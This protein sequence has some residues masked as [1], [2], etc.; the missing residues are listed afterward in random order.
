MTA[1]QHLRGFCLVAI[2]LTASGSFGQEAERL[3]LSGRDKDDAVPWKFKCTSG[4]QSGFWTNLPVPSHWEMYGFGSLNY[5]KDPTN[6]W[7]EQGLYDHEFSIPAEWHD[8]RVFLVFEGVMTDTSARLNGQSVGPMHQGSFYRFKYEVT[9]LAKCGAANRLEVTV[10]KHS[11]NASVNKAERNADYWVFG[12]IY[13]P[14][15]LEAVPQQFIDRVAIDAQANGAL[16]VEAF[17]DGIPDGGTI[18]AQVLQLDGKP[19]GAAF[20]G[21]V[22]ASKATLTARVSR[23][24]TWTAETPNLY[25]LQ[26]SFKQGNRIIHMRRHRFGFR[27]FEV[28][29]G[30]GLYLN[31]QRV[32][33]Q[34]ADRH[35][36]WPESGRCLSEAIHRLD[37]NALKD[38]NMNAV[39]MSHYPPDQKFLDL[40]DEMGIYVLDE[41]GGWHQSYD[42]QVGTKL[43]GEMIARDVNHPCILFWDNG[44]EG[45]WNTNLDHLFPELDVQHRRVLHPWAPFSGVNTAHYLAYTQAVKACTGVADVHRGKELPPTNDSTRYIYMP[46]EFLHGLYDGGAGAGMEDYWNLMRSSKYLG[47]SF[48][49][50]LTDDGIRRP[51]TGRI[52]VAGNQAPDGIVG[53]YRQREASYYAIKEIWSPIVVLPG[54]RLPANEVRIA[55]RYSFTDAKQCTFTWE[56]RK[57][58]LPNESA[59]GYTVLA[60]GKATV[61]SIWPGAT[62]AIRLGLPPDWDRA[63]AVTL[64]VNDPSGRELWTWVWP[65]L[66]IERFR[67]VEADSEGPQVTTK[68]S[69][70]SIDIRAGDLLV[71]ISKQ[72]GLLAAVQRGGQKYSINNGPRP[73]AGE[74]R[75][76]SLTA[77]P[78]NPHYNVEGTF[79]GNLSSVGWRLRG[80]G[81]LD[82]DYIYSAT[83]SMDFHGVAFDFPE[84]GVKHKKWLGDGPYRVWKNRLQ[85]VSLGIWENDY[86]NTITGWSDWNYPEFK[87]CFADVRWMQF[88]TAE[89]QITIL[90]G[91]GCPFVQVL[92]PEFPPANLAGKTVPMLPRAGLALLNAIPPMGSKFTVASASGPQGQPNAGTGDYWGSISF[93][94]GP[95]PPSPGNK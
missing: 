93:Y 41:L 19:V 37:I 82:C 48:V 25:E 6:A 76:K 71:Q 77:S 53:P 64:Q 90:P 29:D 8:R 68:G 67:G 10:A 14:I 59:A 9:G 78:A 31:G 62:N 39:R 21:G 44:N 1:R 79:E 15:Y 73:A 18:E 57:F 38:A 72:S 35:S 46:T 13:R 80:N 3:Y 55:N 56:L 63:D 4:L 95:L 36:F 66:A 20:A 40:C 24:R 65:S 88:E 32:I 85:G 89:G 23:P 17:G 91:S 69:E 43:V 74:A 26:V 42:T 94:F 81:W 60:E 22:F 50:A 12:G 86:N 87:G 84:S 45:G 75:L 27:T 2:W 49:W 34:G 52:D 5:Y 61:P 30:D 33:L 47:G 92:T 28:R 54:Q 7:D 58:R 51:D 11:A 70:N 16:T 83:G